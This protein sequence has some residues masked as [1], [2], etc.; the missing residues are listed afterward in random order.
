MEHTSLWIRIGKVEKTLKGSLDLISSPSPSWKIQIMGCKVCLKSNGKTLLGTL[1]TNFLYSKVCW[2][3]PAMFC[4]YSSPQANFPP[5]IWIFTE[6]EGDG[7][8]SGLPFQIF[9]TLHSSSSFSHTSNFFFF[10]KEIFCNFLVKTLQIKKSQ[11][12]F[13]PPKTWKKRP[14][15][16]LIIHPIFFRASQERLG[17]PRKP[18]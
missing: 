1:S 12:N 5:I 13:Y 16:M 3:G 15:K 17:L 9:S 11:I 10:I 6:G 4:L 7:I 8:E 2:K 14:Q 18:I